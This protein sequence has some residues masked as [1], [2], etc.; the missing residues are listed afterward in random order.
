MRPRPT[1]R[2]VHQRTIRIMELFRKE[3]VGMD[4]GVMHTIRPIDHQ[5]TVRRVPPTVLFPHL[6]VLTGQCHL[7]RRVPHNHIAQHLTETDLLVI[8]NRVTRHHLSV[9]VVHH[10]TV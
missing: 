4:I 1:I 5:R 3:R 7:L 10:R 9:L 8:I 2:T 6:S